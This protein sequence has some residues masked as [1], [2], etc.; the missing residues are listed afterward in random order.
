MDNAFTIPL[1]VMSLISVGGFVAVLAYAMV[2]AAML[3]RALDVAIERRSDE[4]AALAGLR[5]TVAEKQRMANERRMVR[6]RNHERVEEVKQRIAAAK[7]DRVEFVHE[8]NDPAPRDRLFRIDLSLE[9]GF[10]E[11]RPEDVVFSPEI[12]KK[13][14]VAEVLAQTPEQAM[15]FA[16]KAFPASTGV[17]RGRLKVPG[18][19]AT[20]PVAAEAAS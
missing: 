14:N 17:A 2:R 13:R 3:K 18:E 9:R 19:G 10:L 7:Q 1:A 8:L 11:Q 4:A 12:W 6:Q 20:A 15:E 5:E 16:M